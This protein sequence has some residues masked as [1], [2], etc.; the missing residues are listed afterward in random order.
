MMRRS[1]QL[2]Y[3]I[4]EVNENLEAIVE[5]RT[6]E[7]NLKS[8][9]LIEHEKELQKRN[10]ELQQL[11]SIRNRF[12]TIIGH[13]IRGPV[14][15]NAQMLDILLTE[16]VDDKEKDEVLKLLMNSSKA[17]M[18]L[19]ENLMIWGRSQIGNLIAK[20]EIF[21]LKPIVSA[22]CDLFSHAIQEKEIIL[23]ISIKSSL[24]V[25][26]DKEQIKMLVRNLLS[27]AI[28]FTGNKGVIM[29]GANVTENGKE[30]VL[31]V[32]DSGIGIPAVMQKKLFSSEEFN[33]TDGTS[34]E[35]G[36]GLGL[37]LCHE[38]IEL[39]KGWIKV[40]SK[41]GKGTVFTVGIPV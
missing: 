40:E 26:V 10:A 2:A 39:N 5:D 17:T 38:L 19:L 11:I 13:D 7:L 1:E 23:E 41:T 8:E 22:T 34:N 25:N 18:E 14:G 30:V 33:T 36:S 3:E 27:N 12:F 35:K 20:P 32:S 16:D 37:K 4:F 21:A 15:Y 6:Q 31:T 28:K 29:I 24:K 9:K